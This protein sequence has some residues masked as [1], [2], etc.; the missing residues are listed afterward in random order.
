MEDLNNLIKPEL[1]ILV[2]ILYLIGNLFKQSSLIK[3]QFIPLYL[4]LASIILCGIRIFSDLP[5]FTPQM[6]LMGLFSS[7]TQGI[8]VA[9][10]SV[11]A[12]QIYHQNTKPNS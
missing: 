7:V 3:D 11:Y 8:L 5:I 2:P 9:S 1:L 6:I 12:H 10:A 4:G